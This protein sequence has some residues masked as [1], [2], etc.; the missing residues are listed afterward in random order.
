MKFGVSL[1]F[2]GPAASAEALQRAALRA[3]ELGF[4]SVWVADHVLIPEKVASRYPYSASGGFSLRWDTPFYDPLGALGFLAGVTRRVRL[5][6]SVLVLPYR[7]A[8]A[9]GK[10]LATIDNLAGGR[11]IL[12]IGVGWMAEEF[13]ALGLPPEHYAQRGALTDECIGAFRALWAEG[14]SSFHGRFYNFE[15]VGAYPKPAQ[16]GGIPIWVGGNTGRALRRTAQLGDGWHAVALPLE[17]F[18]AKLGEL[19][20]AC[21]AAGRDPAT[22]TISLRIGVYQHGAGDTTPPGIAIPGQ[23]IAGDAASLAG[24]LAAFAEAGAQEMLVSFRA[25][26]SLDEYLGKLERFREVMDRV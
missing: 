25:G 19:H 18:G 15:A 10:A 7:N 14:P 12:G 11:L 2:T 20:H 16:A 8:V 24:Q 26:G 4:D 17:A 9:T 3:E 21:A 23:T 13:E 22:L 1:P 6:V 5:G